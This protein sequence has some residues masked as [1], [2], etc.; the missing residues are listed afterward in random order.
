LKP[1]NAILS[2]ERPGFHPF[3]GQV[4]LQG[5]VTFNFLLL[6]MLNNGGG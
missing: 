4:F 6:P 2:A 3:V 1:G 5:A